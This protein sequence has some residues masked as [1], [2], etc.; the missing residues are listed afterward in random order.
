[1]LR[2]DTSRTEKMQNIAILRTWFLEWNK[3]ITKLQ[4]YLIQKSTGYTFLPGVYEVFD[5]NSMLKSLLPDLVKV[6]IKID[7]ISLR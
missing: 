3:D 1:M 4:R 5:F 6:E 7:D 2:R